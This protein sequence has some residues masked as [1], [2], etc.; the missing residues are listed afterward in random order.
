MEQAPPEVPPTSAILRFRFGGMGEAYH[1]TDPALSPFGGTL[2]GPG[3][4]KAE[5]VLFN[6]RLSPEFLW[7]GGGGSKS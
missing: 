1:K 2:W 5:D 6:T 3:S 4:T 7:V